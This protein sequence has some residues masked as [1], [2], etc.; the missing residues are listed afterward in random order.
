[1]KEWTP[2]GPVCPHCKAPNADNH[3]KCGSCDQNTQTLSSLLLP[4]DARLTAEE[5]CIYKSTKAHNV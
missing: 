1:M 4:P 3:D 2:N 5:L